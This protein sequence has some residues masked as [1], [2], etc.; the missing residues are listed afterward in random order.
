MALSPPGKEVAF[1]S[2]IN[3]LEEFIRALSEPITG[4]HPGQRKWLKS[5]WV[6]AEIPMTCVW[7]CVC[8]FVV[9]CVCV[10]ICTHSWWT[11]SQY[12]C[13]ITIKTLLDY[14]KSMSVYYVCQ[15]ISGWSVALLILKWLRGVSVW[16]LAPM[17]LL[18]MSDSLKQ[19]G[20]LYVLVNA[21][22]QAQSALGAHS[23][24]VNT[25]LNPKGLFSYV[26]K[27]GQW[28]EVAGCSSLY[29][30][31]LGRSCYYEAGETFVACVGGRRWG[32]KALPWP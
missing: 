11:Y 10:Y 21:Y 29:I 25:M 3:Q 9:E 2:T 27:Y 12:V 13:G 14:Q 32:V 23:V 18:L 31:H 28:V 17:K 26:C 22:P 20:V 30:S 5:W 15:L 4:L 1:K 8:T 24:Q 19:G 6:W 7:Q 16:C